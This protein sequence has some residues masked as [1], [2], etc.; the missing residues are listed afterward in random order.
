MIP[1]IAEYLDVDP[2]IDLL[3]DLYETVKGVRAGEDF[4]TF[5]KTP[6]E[7]YSLEYAYPKEGRSLLTG[8]E[9]VFDPILSQ[10]RE[11]HPDYQFRS[12]GFNTADSTEKDVFPHTDIDQNQKYSQ[13]YNIIMPVFGG[14][15]LDY[16]ETNQDEV[17]LPEHNAQGYFYYHEFYAQAEMG[18]GSPEFEQFLKDRKIGEIIIDKPCLIDT[19]IMHRVVITEAPRCAFVTRWVNIPPELSDFHTFKE[20]VEKTLK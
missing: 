14:S 1:N 3:L 20:R 11:V 6:F 5:G 18:Q 10:H 15:R 13:G 2:Q 7:S 16:Y 19:E 8:Y 17:F 4:N 9:E 12:T